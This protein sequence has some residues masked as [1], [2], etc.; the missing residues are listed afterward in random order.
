[1]KRREFIS[2]VAGIAVTLPLAARAQGA[3]R[4][5]KLGFQLVH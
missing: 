1:M 2:L 3:G 5:Y 4:L